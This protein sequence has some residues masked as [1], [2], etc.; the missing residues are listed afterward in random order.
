[1]PTAR[2]PRSTSID[3]KTF[4]AN[5]DDVVANIETVIKGK[6]DVVR[7]ALVA[8][9]C[10]G[11]ILFE[12]VP[13]TGKSMLARAIGQSINAE[14]SRVQCTPDML[15]GDI[16]GSSILDQKKGTFEFRPGPV[17]TNILLSDEINRATPKTQ[18]ALLEAMAE[19][20]LTAD[21]V[22]YDLPRPFLVLATQNPI[23]TAGTF[24]L[25]E[26]QLDRF[27]FK[28][29]MGYMARDHEFE[30]MFDNSV[31]LSIEDLGSVID[32]PTVQSMIDYAT[33]VEV[34]PEV[35]YY[36]VDLVHASRQD[37]AV[38]MGGSPRASIALLRAGRVLAASDGREHVYPD[39]IRAVLRPVMAH[40]VVL[41]P[42]A[43]LRGDSVD[44]VLE[45]VTG[46][47]KP[48]LSARVA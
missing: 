6:T 29:S 48:P 34:S 41:N 39:D 17:F 12:D 13:G 37:P 4:K 5:F 32:T 22:T 36:I 42:E 16:T 23:E 38:S 11:H 24:P 15:P 46:A 18:S 47:V 14:T 1:M 43:I 40:R 33:T 19:R 25:P 3:A 9:L 7:L 10:E 45:R 44:A 30:V 21:G 27:I 35:G 28:M 20:R 8:I 26:A 31:Q 2:R